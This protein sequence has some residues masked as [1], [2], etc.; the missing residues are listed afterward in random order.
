MPLTNERRAPIGALFPIN[1]A[2]D[3]RLQKSFA[4]KYDMRHITSVI[5]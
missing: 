1:Q 3:S 2:P 5:K 4:T